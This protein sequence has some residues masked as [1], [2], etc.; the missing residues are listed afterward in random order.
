MVGEHFNSQGQQNW[1]T[2]LVVHNWPSAWAFPYPD[3]VYAILNCSLCRLCIETGRLKDSLLLLRK[4]KPFY[5]LTCLVHSVFPMSNEIDWLFTFSHTLLGK[6]TLGKEDGP[7]LTTSLF[8]SAPQNGIHLRW[9]NQTNFAWTYRLLICHALL[10][11]SCTLKY[12]RSSLWWGGG[13]R[14]RLNCYIS[15]V[16]FLIASRSRNNCKCLRTLG[17][18][19]HLTKSAFFAICESSRLVVLSSSAKALQRPNWGRPLRLSLEL[20]MI[21]FFLGI[22]KLE[23]GYYKKT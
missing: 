12:L 14:L 16:A 18:N 1:V 11:L 7:L 8:A 19:V 5:I 17:C 13:R 2:D 6:V 15:A 4:M 21:F 3:R 10:G 22:A 23:I 9:S 20:W